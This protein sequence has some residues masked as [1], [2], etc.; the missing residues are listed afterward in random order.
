MSGSSSSAEPGGSS[1]RTAGAPAPA[2]P[3]VGD[4]LYT[5]PFLFAST[6]NALFYANINA[7]NLL[8]LYIGA[9]GGTESHIGAIMAMYQVAAIVCQVG[10]P[11]SDRRFP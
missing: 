4:T 11:F 10:D 7:F 1:E 2:L 9:L 6:A 3:A 8:P 5:R